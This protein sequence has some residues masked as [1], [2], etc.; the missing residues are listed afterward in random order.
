[1][2]SLMNV[3]FTALTGIVLTACG[4]GGGSGASSINPTATQA[5]QGIQSTG[6]VSV[7]TAH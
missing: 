6:S 5:A 4:G 1:M 2:K 3:F 7:V